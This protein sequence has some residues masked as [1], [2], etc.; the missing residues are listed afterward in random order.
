MTITKNIRFLLAL[1]AFWLTA[2]NLYPLEFNRIDESNGLNDNFILSLLQDSRGFMWVGTMSGAF[3]YDGYVFSKI[4]DVHTLKA[5]NNR[6]RNIKEDLNGDIWFSGYNGSVH[7]YNR[8]Q[9]LVTKSFPEDLGADLKL[10]SNNTLTIVN[11]NDKF[12]AFSRLGFLHINPEGNNHFI[13]FDNLKLKEEVN[14]Y[15]LLE[16]ESKKI[17]LG[18]NQGLWEYRTNEKKLDLIVKGNIKNAIEREGSLYFFDD[19]SK[20]FKTLVLTNNQIK[21]CDSLNGL[22]IKQLHGLN[23]G[24]DDI[25]WLSTEKG[26][27]GMSKDDKSFIVPHSGESEI[28]RIQKVYVDLSNN[29]W[30]LTTQAKGIYQYNIFQQKLK[31]YPVSL[32]NSSLRNNDILVSYFF[33]DRQKNLWVGTSADGLLLYDRSKDDFKVFV[34]N[35]FD[36]RSISSN[37]QLAITQ[38]KSGYLWFGTRKGGVSILKMQ[39]GAFR[40]IIPNP[41]VGDKLLNEV[42]STLIYNNVHILST[43]GGEFYTF[44]PQTLAVKKINLTIKGNANT[45]AMIWAMNMYVDSRNNIWISTKYSGVY[46]AE[47]YKDENKLQLTRIS[48][49]SNKSLIE[50]IDY[51]GLLEDND[52]LWVASHG[53]GMYYIDL[54]SKNPT[55]NIFNSKNKPVSFHNLRYYRF[56]YKD[57]KGRI[58]AGGIEGV[59]MF[60]YNQQTD[61]FTTYKNFQYSAGKNTIPYHDVNNVYETKDSTIWMATNGGGFCKYDEKNDTFKSYGIEEGLSSSIVYGLIEDSRGVLWVSTSYGLSKFD[62]KTEKINTYFKESGLS[63]S[64]M[65]EFSPR[66][67]NL[68]NLYFGTTSGL[69]IFNP[70]HVIDHPVSAKILISGFYISNKPINDFENININEVDKIDLDYNQ[71]DISFEFSSDMFTEP[72]YRQYEYMLKGYDVTW[73]TAHLENKAIYTNLNPGEYEFMVRILGVEDNVRTLK[74]HIHKHPLKTPVAYLIYILLLSVIGYVIFRITYRYYKLDNNL[75]IERKITDVK[76]MFFTNISHELRTLLTLIQAPLEALESEKNLNDRVLY[77]VSTIRKNTNILLHLVGDILDFRKIQSHKMKLKVTENEILSFF[78][79]ISDLFELSIKSKGINYIVEC[80]N[81]EIYGWFDLEKMEKVLTNLL[82]NALKFTPKKGTITCKLTCDENNM[83]ITVRDTGI[84]FDLS[85]K[86][87]FERFFQLND[88]Y[89]HSGSGIGLSLIKEFVNL[90]KGKLDVESTPG[91][92]SLFVISIP[93]SANAYKNDEIADESQWQLGSCA[94]LVVGRIEN[95][96]S[97]LQNTN[98]NSKTELILVVEDNTELRDFLVTSLSKFFM[99]ESAE[100]GI[101]G[102]HKTNSLNPDL[103]ITDVV[104]PNLDGIE[105]VKKIRGKF[106][107]NHIPIIML[108]AK[109]RI[110]DKIDG[111]IVGADDYIEKPFNLNYLLLRINNLIS[112]R[113]LLKSRFTH[114]ID[115]NK[116]IAD[117]DE[118]KKFLSE[119]EE[120]VNKH[121]DESDFGVEELSKEMFYSKTQFFTKI[122]QVTGCSPNQYIKMIR[123]KKA[124]EFLL[125]GKLTISEICYAVGYNDIDHFRE[126]FKNMFELTP[127]QYKKNNT[128]FQKE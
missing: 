31:L 22:G 26:F 32:K 9:N 120:M 52:I 109:S 113:K 74:V 4:K 29:I 127:S 94:E 10:K 47:F 85:N 25:I 116:I 84:G 37:S 13:K 119:I 6:I 95:E 27:V 2:I 57:K 33:E 45:N 21:L 82:S 101:E 108:T 8:K 96:F 64:T 49:Q 35:Q 118:D 99:V 111:I 104:M 63:T 76:L 110:E 91:V 103:I 97:G 124:S 36:S 42:N 51:Y 122:K 77:L 11:N 105:M 7:F 58:W 16:T 100:D 53:F 30:F 17:L 125:Q 20:V 62:R 50:N 23:R 48:S 59:V 72:T 5:F 78:R 55:L 128:D 102:Y 93:I 114:N 19:Q 75:K 43:I 115:V 73:H 123:L 81:E 54:T 24:Y 39:Q 56:V 88:V 34:N 92:G 66:T 112:R 117:N 28:G 15:F 98:S 87:L 69:L 80:P 126:Q 14:A 46:K 41:L 89:Q 38:D 107:I 60:K 12:F 44:D 86:Q 61:K 18:T 40:S 68:G 70:S 67:D 79:V 3:K 106:E 121:L 83:T 90:H 71:K 1:L 65:S